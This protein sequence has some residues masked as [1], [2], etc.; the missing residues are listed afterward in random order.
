MGGTMLLSDAVLSW[1]GQFILF[2]IGALLLTFAVLAWTGIWREW[3]RS[4][5]VP[6]TATKTNVM[7]FTMG[8]L[9]LSVTFFGLALNISVGVLPG[10]AQAANVAGGVL[11]VLAW[12]STLWWPSAVTPAWHRDWVRRG[13]NDRTSPWPSALHRAQGHR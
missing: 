3:A 8:L 6:L 1:I 11:A 2:I 5:R 12:I 4:P 7:P 10:S 13:G 9:G